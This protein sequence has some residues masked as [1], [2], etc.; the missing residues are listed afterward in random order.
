MRRWL[1][2]GAQAPHPRLVAALCVLTLLFGWGAFVTGGV[3]GAAEAQVNLGTADSFGVLAGTGVTNGGPTIIVGDLGSCPTPAVTGMPPLILTGSLHQA[4]A[5]ACGAQDDLTIAYDDAAGRAPGTTYAGP[6]ELGGL[7]LTPGV[8]M[9]PTSFAITGTL[10]LNALNDPAAVF[11]FQAGSTF[12]TATD[13]RVSFIN[14]G[15]PCNVYWQVGSSATIGVRSTVVGSVLALTSISA[16]TNAV[17]QGRL[18]ARNG[19][20]TLLSNVITRPVCESI[21]TTTE[22]GGGATTTAPDGGGATTTTAGG[23]GGTTTTAPDGGGATTTTTTAGGGGATTTTAPGGG[24]ATTTTAGGGG[25]TTT[26]PGGGSA[27][28]TTPGGGAATTTV[29]GATQ[30]ATTVP[31]GSG[32]QA[33]TTRLTTATT[34]GRATVVST[35]ATTTLSGRTTT[36]ARTTAIP[37]TGSSG[38]RTAYIA[39]LAISLGA[40]MIVLAGQWSYYEPRRDWSAY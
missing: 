10:T 24:G 27:T 9:T 1:R 33:T 6:T 36:T 21:P 34:A 12:G 40:L 7:T 3:A 25:A 8:Y 17:I 18:L 28:T 22:G 14:G 26:T 39:G 5:V 15:S 11:I 20:V 38:W 30:T 37:R 23:G 19:A 13:S 31:A 16:N 29:V 32:S 35:G 2:S 4:D